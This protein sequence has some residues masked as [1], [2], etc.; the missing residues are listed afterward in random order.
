MDIFFQDPT[1]VPLS[2][3]EVRI[4]DVSVKP[5]PDGRR[6]RVHVELDPFQKRP[7][8][9][10][11]IVDAQDEQIAQAQVIET[12]S[13]RLEMT[14]HLRGSQPLGGYT[15]RVLLYYEE[16]PQAIQGEPASEVPAPRVVDRRQVSFTLA[17]ADGSIPV[18]GKP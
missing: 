16:L 6:V 7:N 17:E 8:L 2:P 4:R 1:E 12:M 5:Y 13:R 11:V 9:E 15:L 10:L 18:T 14:L 3:D